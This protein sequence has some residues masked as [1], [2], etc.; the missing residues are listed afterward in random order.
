MA[1]TRSCVTGLH[2][3]IYALGNVINQGAFPA[4]RRTTDQQHNE[5]GPPGVPPT[6]LEFSEQ[7]GR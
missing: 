6:L 2:A 1:F 7:P 4:L 3:S 5:F